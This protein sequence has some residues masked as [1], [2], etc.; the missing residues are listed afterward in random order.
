MSLAFKLRS[1]K[2]L[3]LFF[4]ECYSDQNSNL[5]FDTQ[6]L[7]HYFFGIALNPETKLGITDSFKIL[8]SVVCV[9]HLFRSF[10]I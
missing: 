6:L 2:Q 8:F 3:K 4:C 1:I 7:Q 10:K 5:P 9:L